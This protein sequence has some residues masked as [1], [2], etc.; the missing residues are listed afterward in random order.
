MTKSSEY[1]REL[2]KKQINTLQASYEG[3][4]KRRDRG[5]LTTK[6]KENLLHIKKWQDADNQTVY[7]FFF[8]MRESAKTAFSDFMLLCETL[9]EKQLIQ[10]FSNNIYLSEESKLS[11]STDKDLKKFQ[12]TYPLFKYVVRAM[13]QDR[14][15]VTLTNIKSKK[16]LE[17]FD[18][19]SWQAYLAH[20]LIGICLEFFI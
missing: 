17:S 7:Q 18:D 14:S 19:D 3:Y 6:E 12:R 4:L 8:D 16:D 9:N 2:N 20:D 15:R 10:I 13:L 5:F 1:T 11:H